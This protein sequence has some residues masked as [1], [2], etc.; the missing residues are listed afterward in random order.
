L[1]RKVKRRIDSFKAIDELERI[2]QIYVFQ[3]FHEIRQTSSPIEWLPGLKS[4]IDGRYRGVQI[5]DESL[6]EYLIVQEN[7]KVKRLDI[8]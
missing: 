7:V 3:E 1:G 6:G 4:A 8:Q 2:H 5:L